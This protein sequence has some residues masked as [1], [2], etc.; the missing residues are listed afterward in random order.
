MTCPVYRRHSEAEM[1]GEG[2]AGRLSVVAE[3]GEMGSER[4]A[5]LGLTVACG[6]PRARGGL[7]IVITGVAMHSAGQRA[8]I[9]VGDQ[10]LSVGPVEGHRLASLSQSEVGALLQG[11]PDTPVSIGIA[12]RTDGTLQRMTLLAIRAYCDAGAEASRTTSSPPPVPQRRRAATSHRL[13]RGQPRD[14]S[15]S[16]EATVGPL[17]SAPHAGHSSERRDHLTIGRAPAAHQHEVADGAA[18]ASMSAQTP[19]NVQNAIGDSVAASQ[20]QKGEAGG[21]D[22]DA[23]PGLVTPRMRQDELP[24][25]YRG[26][27]DIVTPSARLQHERR[28]PTGQGRVQSS[29]NS[30]A[31]FTTPCSCCSSSCTKLSSSSQS[32]AMLQDMVKVSPTQRTHKHTRARVVLTEIWMEGSRQTDR[33]RGIYIDRCHVYIQAYMHTCLHNF[34]AAIS[35]MHV[36]RRA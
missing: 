10:L 6:Q 32:V 25:H 19:Q 21:A 34:L 22:E 15:L 33:Q 16:V 27:S 7:G 28:S 1:W 3:D 23:P 2:E 20:H 9:R 24:L 17:Q 29:G 8:G 36:H 18:R 35:I 26:A 11:P 4:R 30:H 14:V 13:K 5:N 31:A 12:R